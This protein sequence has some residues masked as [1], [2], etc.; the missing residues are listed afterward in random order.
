LET[1]KATFYFVNGERQETDQHKLTVR[2][3]LEGAG[4]RPPEE[5]R[6]VRDD[7]N[8]AFK[9][10]NEDVPVHKDERFTALFEGPTPTS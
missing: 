9:D 8:H 2:A 4:F 1:A 10:L 7:G 3:I 6:L 5:Y